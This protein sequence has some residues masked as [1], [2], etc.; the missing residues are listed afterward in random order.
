MRWQSQNAANRLTTYVRNDVR[1]QI[2]IVSPKNCFRVKYFSVWAHSISVKMTTQYLGCANDSHPDMGLRVIFMNLYMFLCLLIFVVI[3]N[4]FFQH[5]WK[6]MMEVV[7]YSQNNYIF[8]GYNF[9]W[10]DIEIDRGNGIPTNFSSDENLFRGKS[11]ILGE[12][13]DNGRVFKA[14]WF[15][16]VFFCIFKDRI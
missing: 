11:F 1:K 2:R 9:V 12:Y 14:T 6:W 5:F 10:N 16:E 4:R 15:F 8:S 7:N 3:F 13:A